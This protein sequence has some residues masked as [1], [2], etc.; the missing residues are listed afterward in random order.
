MNF[1]A[2]R[3]ALATLVYAVFAH[4]S[5]AHATPRLDCP[6]RD[7]PY[8][9][10]TPLMDLLLKPEAMAVLERA[11]PGIGQNL[12]PQFASPTPPSFSAIL[13]LRQVA[14]YGILRGADITA[15]DAEL[16]AL[17][18]TDADR[19][20]R[21][22]RYDNERPPL[23]FPRS[24]LRVLLFEKMTGFRDGPSVDAAHAAFVA[25]AERNHWTLLST[26][27][28][29]AITNATLRNVD[30]IIWN[31]V[32]G[33]VLTLTQRRALQ[34][35]MER[36]GGF[37]AVHGSGGDPTY[38]WDWYVDTLIGA[39]F[40]GHPMAPQFQEARV[41]VP[42]APRTIGRNLAPGWSMSDE[43][44]SF[45][46]SPRASGA[47]IIAELDE[48]TYSPV[49]MMNQEL[50]M[51]DHPIAWS[52]CVRNGRSFYSAIGHRPETY[53]DPHYVDLLQQ[54]I[55]WAA[56]EGETLCRNGQERPR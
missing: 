25:M 48:S 51:G 35:Y 1:S 26:D 19:I 33:D 2:L 34:R 24:G 31:N 11:A 20:A 42:G 7:A 22:A 16:R 46:A 55:I 44:Y 53:S 10:E 13:N 43:W 3:I 45:A 47:T 28:G 8:S 52:R 6:L 32:S 27:R 18:V 54:A 37:V 38:F 41:V 15:V 29:G 30:V 40:I 21:C 14:A 56:G 4:L 9:A 12:P 50:R 49:G 39:R 5:A 23:D 36:G 17:P